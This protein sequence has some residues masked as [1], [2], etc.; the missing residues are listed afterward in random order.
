MAKERNVNPATAALKASKKKEIK[1]SKANLANQRAEKFARR[2][3]NRLQKQIDDLKAS[4]ASGTLRPKDKQTLEQLEKDL[5]TVY[6]ARE[7]LGDKAPQYSQ[8]QDDRRGSGDG[9]VLGKRRRDDTHGRPRR[10]SES[11]TD[12]DAKDIPM[13]KDVE[14]MPSMPRRRPRNANETPLGP[15]RTGPHELPPKPVIPVQTVY[16]SAPVVRNL[17]KEAVS[18]FVPSSVAKNIKRVKGDGELLEPEE[19]D[20]LEKL[21][22]M[23]SEKAAEEAIKE[24][25]YKIMSEEIDPTAS[26]DLDEE[27][28]KFLREKQ[29]RQVEMEEIEDE[30][31]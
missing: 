18:R 20:R 16:E 12:E 15:S 24:A 26:R 10:D 4:E 31:L 28:A 22:Y 11:E 5:R 3:P 6:K 8:W 19:A 2:N 29:L 21:G 9:A 1:K 30:D 14:N 13:P 27:T 25:E 23:D 17:R 7:L